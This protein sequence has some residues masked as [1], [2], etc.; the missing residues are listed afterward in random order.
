ML[1]RTPL[2]WAAGN[3]HNTIAQLLLKKKVDPD[4]KTSN[5][6]TPLSWAAGNGHEAVVRLL[7]EQHGVQVDSKDPEFSATPLIRAAENG[8]E[9]VVRLLLENG[10]DVEAK[11][12]WL[13]TPL[14]EASFNGD[15][16]I[17][18]LLKSKIQ[19]SGRIPS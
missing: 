11:N 15:E 5:G 8:H 7:L 12:K 3:G 14:E 16:A 1:G 18:Q 19:S 9:A 10:A 17:V 4:S 6:R 2:S 13:I